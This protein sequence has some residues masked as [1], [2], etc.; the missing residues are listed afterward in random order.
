MLHERGDR[1]NDVRDRERK[2]KKLTEILTPWG[3]ACTWRHL[4]REATMKAGID[5]SKRR[6]CVQDEGSFRKFG[7]VLLL[8]CH[9]YGSERLTAIAPRVGRAW[10]AAGGS[11]VVAGWARAAASGRHPRVGRRRA[12][13]WAAKRNQMLFTAKQKGKAYTEE[14]ENCTHL[15]LEPQKPQLQARATS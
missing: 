10:R 4:C 7:T 12:R 8:R 13:A 1:R 14:P 2:R 15:L 6:K 9:R 5:I 11:L 3:K